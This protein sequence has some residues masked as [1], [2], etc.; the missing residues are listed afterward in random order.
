M[1]RVGGVLIWRAWLPRNLHPLI[2]LGVFALEN[3]A[4][5]HGR[6]ATPR[7]DRHCLCCRT[8]TTHAHHSRGKGRKPRW[9]CLLCLRARGRTRREAVPLEPVWRDMV[10]R[11]HHPAHAAWADY[12]GRGI[13]V[14]Q[15]WRGWPAGYDRWLAHMGPRPEGYTLERMDNDGNYE[16]GNVRWATWAEQARNRR[17][18]TV[19]TLEGRTQTLVEWLEEIGLPRAT[20]AYRVSVGWSQERALLTP[21]VRHD[22]SLEVCKQRQE[23]RRGQLLT[24]VYQGRTHSLTVSGWACLVG[25]DRRTLARRL[26]KGLTLEEALTAPATPGRSS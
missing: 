26:D 19:V 12:G 14:Y 11:C 20:H 17:N 13:T 9:K 22:V 10:A 24:A 5:Y 15:S 18:N 25:L 6:M 2:L 8:T 3:P 4:R 16:P 21:V 7:S 23:A 1:K